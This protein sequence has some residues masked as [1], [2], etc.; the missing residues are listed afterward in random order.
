MD[1]RKVRFGF[2]IC[3]RRS[4]R[5]SQ[6]IGQFLAL[7]GESISALEGFVCTGY[8]GIDLCGKRLRFAHE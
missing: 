1:Y 6:T 7:V 3:D 4:F 8:L 5:Q 2:R